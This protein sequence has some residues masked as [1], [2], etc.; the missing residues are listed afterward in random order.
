MTLFIIL[1]LEALTLGGRTLTGCTMS[2]PVDVFNRCSLPSLEI[3]YTDAGP[4]M[5]AR[6]PLPPPLPEV[7]GTGPPRAPRPA[8]AAAGIVGIAVRPPGQAHDELP[9]CGSLVE[10][11][12]CFC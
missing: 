3:A 1:R 5:N 4:P 7:G 6:P 8:G 9:A 2:S 10:Y 11:S 12:R